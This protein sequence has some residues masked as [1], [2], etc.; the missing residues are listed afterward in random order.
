MVKHNVVVGGRNVGLKIAEGQS[1]SMD[2]VLG[3]RRH[4]FPDCHVDLT[5]DKFVCGS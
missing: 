3:G 1:L 5:V 2:C 4:V